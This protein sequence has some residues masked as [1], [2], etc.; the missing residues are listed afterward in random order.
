MKEAM[1]LCDNPESACSFQDS[2]HYS[3]P[4]NRRHVE[5]QAQCWTI[6]LIKAKNPSIYGTPAGFKCWQ[7]TCFYLN[8]LISQANYVHRPDYI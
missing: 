8:I 4:A 7:L 2:S 3:V 6:Q 1:W 5:I